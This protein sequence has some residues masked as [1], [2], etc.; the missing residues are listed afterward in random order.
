MLTKTGQI[1]FGLRIMAACGIASSRVES[2]P[3][4][5]A[6]SRVLMPHG[7]IFISWTPPIGRDGHFESRNECGTVDSFS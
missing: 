1:P 7:F 6:E 2:R 5:V 4:S 3:T